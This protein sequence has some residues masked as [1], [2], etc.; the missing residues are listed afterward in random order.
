MHDGGKHVAVAMWTLQEGRSDLTLEIRLHS[1][2]NGR[3]RPRI[4][5]LHVL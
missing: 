2:A 3:W 4:L 1:D 5:D